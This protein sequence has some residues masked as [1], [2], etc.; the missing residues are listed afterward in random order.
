MVKVTDIWVG[1][2]CLKSGLKAECQVNIWNLCIEIDDNY[3]ISLKFKFL[4]SC[5][6]LGFLAPF[7]FG[8]RKVKFG[9]EKVTHSITN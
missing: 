4:L 3:N 6:S 8:E 1:K 5:L 7:F 2:I 9:D